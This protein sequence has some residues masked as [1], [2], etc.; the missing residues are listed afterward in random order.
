MDDVRWDVG[1][2]GNGGRDVH[3]ARPH[4]L[5]ATSLLTSS[6]ALKHTPSMF[7]I[8]VLKIRI[9]L[10]YSLLLGSQIKRIIR[11]QKGINQ[12]IIVR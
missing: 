2:V 10:H 8:R 3:P 11:Y 12:V 9:T 5:P 6:H 7:T 1:V 4:V